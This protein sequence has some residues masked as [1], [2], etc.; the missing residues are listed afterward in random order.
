M[1]FF[2]IDQCNE[3]EPDEETSL[4]LTSEDSKTYTEGHSLTSFHYSFQGC[5][6]DD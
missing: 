3:T 1:S 2:L 6:Q 5:R 4:G